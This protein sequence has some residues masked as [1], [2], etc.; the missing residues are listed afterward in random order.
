M[1]MGPIVTRMVT[2]W[3]DCGGIDMQGKAEPSRPVATHPSVKSRLASAAEVP[4]RESAAPS[5]DVKK[6]E[7]K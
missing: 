7:N 2:A 3:T 6:A 5:G 4:A 1:M